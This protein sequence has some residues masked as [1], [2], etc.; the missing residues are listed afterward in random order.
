MAYS[1]IW[2]LQVLQDAA[3]KVAPVDGWEDRGNGDV[4]T[5]VGVICHHTAG[6][7]NGNM[8]SL[9]TLLNG[10]SDLPG[11]LAQLGLGRDGT[12]YV[13]AAGRC[14]HAGQGSWQGV[15]TGNSAAVAGNSHQPRHL[16]RNR[17]LFLLRLRRVDLL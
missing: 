9:R 17:E 11:P 16:A 13:I 8:P 14:N 1:L 5:T 12:F 3:L 7:R 4:R 6:P 2:L 10:R 15:T